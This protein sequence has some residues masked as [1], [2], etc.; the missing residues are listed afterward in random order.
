[1]LGIGKSIREICKTLERVLE[2]YVRHGKSIREICKTLERVLENYVRHRKEY[3]RNMQDS[4]RSI[5]E[6]C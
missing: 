3:Q 5:R 1:M 4:A 6:L 2:N